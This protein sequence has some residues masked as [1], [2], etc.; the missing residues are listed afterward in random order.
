[1][2]YREGGAIYALVAALLI[3]CISSRTSRI[4]LADQAWVLHESRQYAPSAGSINGH[5]TRLGIGEERQE[6]V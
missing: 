1:M 6:K 3:L 5:F 4:V 2:L